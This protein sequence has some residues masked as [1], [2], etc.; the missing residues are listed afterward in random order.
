MHS[1]DKLLK[2]LPKEIK[3]KLYIFI[4]LLIIATLF[5]LLSISALIPI[6]EIIINGKTSFQFI[7]NY[8]EYSENNLIKNQII[9]AA[10]VF[11]I[12]LFLLKTLYLIFFSY[13]TNKFSQNVFK[14]LSEKI[15]GKYLNNNYL[16]FVNQKSSDLIRN[17]I[18]E[19]KN[20]SQMT[21]C[22]L[23]ILVELFVFITIAIL[24]LIID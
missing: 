21:F 11:I 20:L 5:E 14:I 24:I 7:N 15:L 12:F 16:F 4:V 9:L 8:I 2:I 10:L 6:A 22:Y 17:I 1:I 19:A 18:F 13:W 23:K 3:L